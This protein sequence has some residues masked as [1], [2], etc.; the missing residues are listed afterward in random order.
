MAFVDSIKKFL[1]PV[2]DEDDMDEVEV[3][4]KVAPKAEREEA[5]SS[6]TRRTKIVSLS[7]GAK[8]KIVVA[9]LESNS[10]VKPIIDNLKN[11]IPVIVNIAR[12]DRNDAARAVD[13]IYG[14]AY[15]VDGDMKKVSNDI[16]VVTPHGIEIEGDIAAE[17]LGA[18]G[19]SLDV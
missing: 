16:F 13:V 10:G 18:D 9:K 1:V 17:I 8:Q 5:A 6:G 11:K 15:A 4:E 12:L 7:S 14:A 3:E 2:V 19:F